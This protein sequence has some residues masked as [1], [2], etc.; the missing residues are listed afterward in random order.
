ME[1]SDQ[2]ATAKTAIQD[3]T[4]AEKKKVVQQLNS[5]LFPADNVGRTLIWVILLVGLFTL[6]AISLI[7]AAN[8]S[9]D[10]DGTAY[11]SVTTAVAA[12]VIG[13]FAKSP[14]S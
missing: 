2:A 3:L 14:T 4:D 5:E 11:V 1:L 12:G 9:P 10:R 7:V 13:L 8:L 6:A